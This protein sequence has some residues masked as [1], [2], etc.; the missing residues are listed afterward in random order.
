ML[1]LLKETTF[2]TTADGG[3]VCK[4]MTISML[5]CFVKVVLPSL[6]GDFDRLSAD[7]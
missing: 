3:R 7:A 4:Y 2:A 5:T 1:M 6:S